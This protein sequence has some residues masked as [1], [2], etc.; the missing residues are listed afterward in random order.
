[1]HCDPSCKHEAFCT[2]S[3]SVPTVGCSRLSILAQS[4]ALSELL[5]FVSRIMSGNADNKELKSDPDAPIVALQPHHSKT[6]RPVLNY[7]IWDHLLKSRDRQS[8]KPVFCFQ[9]ST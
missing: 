1:M 7:E 3:A 5:W 4:V 2:F 6:F 9:G 8:W